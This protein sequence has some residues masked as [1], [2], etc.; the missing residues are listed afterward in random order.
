MLR[1]GK[2]TH[3]RAPPLQG[4][5]CLAYALFVWLRLPETRGYDISEIQNMLEARSLKDGEEKRETGERGGEATSNQ[6]ARLDSLCLLLDSCS[7]G[8]QTQLQFLSY[9]AAAPLLPPVVS[10]LLQVVEWVPFT[11]PPP[12]RRPTDVN[13]RRR[14]QQLADSPTGSPRAGGG[15][16]AEEDSTWADW[17]VW[18]GGGLYRT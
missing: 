1:K 16:G 6:R 2:G 3:P 5:L 14:I 4:V 10:S 13:L 8:L 18:G 15:A 9:D 12:R 7:A 17:D 11:D